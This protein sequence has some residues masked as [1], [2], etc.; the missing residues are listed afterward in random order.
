MKRDPI[1]RRYGLIIGL[2]AS[3]LMLLGMMIPQFQYIAALNYIAIPIGIILCCIEYSRERDANVNF[4]Q[5]FQIGFYTGLVVTVI[6]MVSTILFNLLFPDMKETTL[7]ALEEAYAQ[8]DVPEQTSDMIVN[9]MDKYWFVTQIASTI[10][11]G[12][13]GSV[14]S[15]LLGAAIAK[16]NPQH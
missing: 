10:F 12:I 15:S 8:Q 4:G 14:I 13:I 2:V 6:L 5:L 16:K 1:V 9:M 3:L 7:Q 11:T